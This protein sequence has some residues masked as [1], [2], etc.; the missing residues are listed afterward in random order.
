MG[1]TGAEDRTA[2]PKA[3][4]RG[5]EWNSC[6]VFVEGKALTAA[7]GG[8][9]TLITKNMNKNSFAKL[10]N[11]DIRKAWLCRIGYHGEP[12]TKVEIAALNEIVRQTGAGKLV[13]KLRWMFDEGPFNIDEV[14]KLID[15]IETLGL[16]PGSD[17]ESLNLQPNSPLDKEISR[18]VVAHKD[19][20]RLVAHVN[21]P[22]FAATEQVAA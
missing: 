7:V 4:L 10:V 21:T 13:V 12:L 2:E 18:Q 6:A 16:R 11:E 15:S 5:R 20:S 3:Y 19:L 1:I 22:S 14:E 8:R 9:H 17:H